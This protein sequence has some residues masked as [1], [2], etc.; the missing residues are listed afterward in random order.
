MELSGQLYAPA[1][2]PLGMQLPV[3][4]GSSVGLRAGL[5]A[6]KNRKL[7]TLPCLELRTHAQPLATTYND[8][9]IPA[10]S[11]K[12]VALYIRWE[13]GKVKKGLV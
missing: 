11:L 12:Y 13:L 3:P 10:T 1:A 6:A 8:G 7:L 5:D 2:L 9:A 4:V